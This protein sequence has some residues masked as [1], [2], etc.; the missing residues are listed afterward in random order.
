MDGC[1]GGWVAAVWSA[2]GVEWRALPLPFG[3]LLAGLAGCA[4][5]AVDVPIGLPRSGYR[6]CDV[7]ARRVLKGAASSVFLVPP[8]AV[9]AAPTYADACAA[10]RAA[11][12]R[13]ISK[14][15]WFLK[16]RILDATAHRADPRLVEAHPELSFRT[17]TGRALGPKRS[18]PGLA[19]RM[20]ALGEHFGD[21]PALLRDAPAAANADDALDA[22]AC[23][24]TARR[25]ADGTATFLGDRGMVI[26]T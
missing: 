16:D 9:L 10:G 2:R 13:A 18:A 3:E 26:A 12:G 20:V 19:A 6:A 7:E 5:I 24:W 11:E 23:A 25:V 15:T 21:V 1:P 17:M 4:T 14:Q 8:R 22:L